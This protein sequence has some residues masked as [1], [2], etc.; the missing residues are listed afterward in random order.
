MHFLQLPSTTYIL[1]YIQ[2]LINSLTMFPF[3]FFF[4][5]FFKQK[6]AYEIGVRLVG[7]EMCIRDSA[8][9]VP[10]LRRWVP[11]AG[12]AGTVYGSHSCSFPPSLIP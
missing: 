3:L 1:C 2:V 12:P 7:S 5:F 8:G 4:F 9:T 11:G 6:T 10:A